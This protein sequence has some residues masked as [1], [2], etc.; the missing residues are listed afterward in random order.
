VSFLPDAPHLSVSAYTEKPD[1]AALFSAICAALESQGAKPGDRIE[2]APR[3]R[4]FD[5][6]SDLAGELELLTPDRTRFAALVSDSDPVR[7]VVSAVYQDKAMGRLGVVLERSPAGQYHP[8]AVLAD[9]KE[10]GLPDFDWT[11]AERRR[12]LK[13][14]RWARD[15]LKLVSGVA[16]PL[17]GALSV[18]D[19]LPPPGLLQSHGDRL[20]DVYVSRRLLEAERRLEARLR[21]CYRDGSVT[22]WENGIF[23]SGWSP[24]NAD[25]RSTADPA[26]VGRRTADLLARAAT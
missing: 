19:T 7:R 16:D 24:F 20:T 21:D 11:S 15:L 13:V 6:R 22:V 23:F 12:A 2:T 1:D 8:V 25:N 17:Y 5:F 18:E 3:S 14:G 26:T 10:L 4:L 9:A